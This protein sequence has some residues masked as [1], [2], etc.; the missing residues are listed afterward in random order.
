MQKISKKRVGI[1]KR[2][3]RSMLVPVV[4]ELFIPPFHIN[5]KCGVF[6]YVCGADQPF[7]FVEINGFEMMIF[8][9]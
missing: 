3:F 9:N 5:C 1:F 2:S 4:F 6:Y 7:C 8:M